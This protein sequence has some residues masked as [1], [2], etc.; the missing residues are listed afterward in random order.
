MR[1]AALLV[2]LLLGGITGTG[3]IA[4]CG[5]SQATR[6]ATIS[7]VDGGVLTMVAALRTYEHQQ[8]EVVIATARAA[9]AAAPDVA[10]KA[11][12]VADGHA[13][14]TALR[15]RT[16][17]AW[18]S[19]D[20]AISALDDARALNDD[21]SLRGAQAALDNAIAALAKLTGGK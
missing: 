5:G 1:A 8:A 16:A 12:A 13:A 10:A 15:E 21:P 2:V 9:V 14:L 3:A 11:K 19:A 18:R 6:S 4:G 17:P 7:S 20:L